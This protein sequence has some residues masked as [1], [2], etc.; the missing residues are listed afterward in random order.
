MSC[1]NCMLL[2]YTVV[3]TKRLRTSSSGVQADF[4]S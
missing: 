3:E 1:N 4:S 2:V